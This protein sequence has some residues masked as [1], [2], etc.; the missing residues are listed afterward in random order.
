MRQHARNPSFKLLHLA[1]LR[2]GVCQLPL[3][4]A[5]APDKV[6]N[7]KDYSPIPHALSLDAP[8]AGSR[9]IRKNSART[10]PRHSGIH[11]PRTQGKQNLEIVLPQ[12]SSLAILRKL[13]ACPALSSHLML[14]LKSRW[15]QHFQAT[16]GFCCRTSFR[17]RSGRMCRYL[18]NS[19]ARRRRILHHT[20]ILVVATGEEGCRISVTLTYLGYSS[21]KDYNQKVLPDSDRREAGRGN[22][23]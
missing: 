13:L 21:Q 10:K 9:Q 8:K 2:H 17:R 5:L 14:Q 7:V 1:H 22:R 15:L 18:N 16:V 20:C 23:V 12:K 19:R 4:Q 6:A 11:N 3:P